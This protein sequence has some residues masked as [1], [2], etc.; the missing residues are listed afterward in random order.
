MKDSTDGKELIRVVGLL[1]EEVD[2]HLEAINENTSEVANNFECLVRLEDKVDVLSERLDKLQLL[3]E[4]HF[5]LDAK[6]GKEFTMLPLTKREQEVF[7]VLYTLEEAGPVDMDALARNASL[8][9]SMVREYIA[10]M[11]AK[12]VPIIQQT[13]LGKVVLA[14]DSDFKREQATKNILNLKQVGLQMI[15]Q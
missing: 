1:R 15:Q 14:L 10:S 4:R 5:G 6:S 8:P 7:L 3:M 2:D 13:S 9:T 12:G 11:T